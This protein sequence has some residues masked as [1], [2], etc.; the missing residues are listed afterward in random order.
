MLYVQIFD[1][2]TGRK[3]KAGCNI[4]FLAMRG[5]VVVETVV[6]MTFSS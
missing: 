1:Y 6:V 3:K 2:I 5:N 4:E